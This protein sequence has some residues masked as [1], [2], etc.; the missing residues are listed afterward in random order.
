MTGIDRHT[1]FV[2]DL[3]GT[4]L[5]S[6]S[7]LQPESAA[8]LNSAIRNGALFS[9]ATARTPSTVSQLL[10]GVGCTLP[11][12]VMTGGALWDP[13]TRRYSDKVTF[14]PSAAEAVLATLR[15]HR[16][17]AFMYALPGEVLEIRHTGI[18]SPLELDFIERRLD[19]PFKRFL[20]PPDGESPFG[21]DFRDV[22]L[23]YAMQPTA[24][25]EK[26]FAAVSRIPGCNPVF[27]H[28]IYGP[29][30]AILEVFDSN[31]SKARALQ[32]LRRRT[33]ATRVV[34]FGDNR[35]D[36][37]MMRG[38]DMAVAVENAIPEV[39]A[40]A[41]IVIGPNTSGAVARFILQASEGRF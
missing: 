1:L 28:D 5:G 15:R 3:D 16:L 34:A 11:W 29:R 27:Y 22:I 25:T 30:T 9:V 31:V 6:D 23:F 35:N 40:A 39:K 17:S 37:P 21:P 19:S 7:L 36:I 33:G 20:I 18:L 38:A 8:M 2:S 4:L 13:L 32:L 24:P 26:A 41:D 12:I 10:A 14:A